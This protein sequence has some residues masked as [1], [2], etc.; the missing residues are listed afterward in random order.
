MRIVSLLPSATDIVASLGL[1]DRLV[2]RTHECDWPPGIEDVPVMTRDEL[3]ASTLRSHEIHAA[4]TNSIGGGSSIYALDHEAL[5]AAQPDLILTQELCEVCAVSYPEVMQAAR[6]LQVGATVVSLE[7][8][9][10]EDIL[11]HV[12]LVGRLAGIEGRAVEVVGDL[13]ARLDRLRAEAAEREPVPT[14]CIEWL[15]PPF[16]AGHWVPEQVG[17][18]GGRE[19]LGEAGSKSR[20]APWDAVVRARPQALIVMPCGMGIER[21]CRE[22]DA[23]TTRPG[24]REL[25]AVRADRVWV[26][27]APAYYNRPGPR[28]V[29]GAE[30]IAALLHGI[31]AAEP[32]EAV[33]LS[34]VA[35]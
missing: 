11:G 23:L 9:S 16:S 12:E 3:D 33:R 25:P 28:V 32:T 8:A 13:R 34:T 10:I 19:L 2:G 22:L 24:W 29:R 14:V 17:V 31:G 18:A 5:S 1:I 6:A 27:D 26:V 7:P 15:D 30:I 35:A 21:A 4:V 20:V